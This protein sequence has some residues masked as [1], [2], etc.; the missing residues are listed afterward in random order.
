MR[1]LLKST[2]N[3][4]RVGPNISARYIAVIHRQ[5]VPRAAHISNCVFERNF[6]RHHTPHAIYSQ[7]LS[8][9]SV[10]L[11]TLLKVIQFGQFAAL[12]EVS[13]LVPFT[14]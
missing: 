2:S 9:P 6:I 1:V 5:Y 8:Y 10:L 14:V 7:N 3:D 11:D 13:C 12:T 4:K